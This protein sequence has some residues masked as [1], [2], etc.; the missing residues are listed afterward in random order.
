MADSLKASL[1]QTTSNPM[2]IAPS[3]NIEDSTHQ[4]TLDNCNGMK[5]DSQFSDDKDSLKR[6]AGSMDVLCQNGDSGCCSST[7]SSSNL[8]DGCKNCYCKCNGSAAKRRCSTSDINFQASDLFTRS[9]SFPLKK[10]SLGNITN[11][12]SLEKIDKINLANLVFNPNFKNS[13]GCV[14]LPVIRAGQNLAQKNAQ[15]AA[16]A[17]DVVKETDI[18]H[19]TQQ[20]A[21]DLIAQQLQPPSLTKLNVKLQ[22]LVQ[23]RKLQGGEESDANCQD[24]GDVVHTF[25]GKSQAPSQS[26]ALRY[27]TELC[28]SYEEGGECRCVPRLYLFSD[29]VWMFFISNIEKGIF[30]VFF[31]SN[32]IRN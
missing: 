19:L 1:I 22:Q 4:Q 14:N 8:K 15:R 3:C 30:I 26:N 17:K 16:L 27:K 13:A 9:G 21:I 5:L 20:A 32:L 28:R 23:Q 31:S 12:K 2:S 7:S 18:N 24:V 11:G 10:N 29:L 6:L 25:S